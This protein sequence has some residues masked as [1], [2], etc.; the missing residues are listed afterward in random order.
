MTIL[1]EAVYL[2]CALTALTCTLLLLRAWAHRRVRLLL[3]SGLC[4]LGLTMENTLLFLEL[5]VLPQ[6]NLAMARNA[7]ALAGLLC[8]VL[9]LIFDRG[10]V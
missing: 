5:V 2:L 10:R 4:F 7:I 6:V 1:P 9:G 3:W 8:L